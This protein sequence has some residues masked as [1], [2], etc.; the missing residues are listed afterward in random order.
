MGAAQSRV[1]WA[2]ISYS[3]DSLVMELQKS[4]KSTIFS[5]ARRH[6][7]Q[8]S[9]QL[10]TYISMRARWRNPRYNVLRARVL[11]E[12]TE[13]DG[14]L[15]CAVGPAVRDILW[16]NFCRQWVMTSK[17]K[18]QTSNA[19][20]FD[21][22]NS[23]VHSPPQTVR[24]WS[25]RRMLVARPLLLLLTTEAQRAQRNFIFLPDREPRFS[26]GQASDRANREPTRR[27]GLQAKRGEKN[28]ALR[29]GS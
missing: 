21:P 13:L 3:I 19:I 29:A 23:M 25:L 9:L 4:R 15:I 24:T 5:E 20:D 8:S 22:P 7:R 26:A 16:K 1:F 27:V 6:D 2:R 28:T 10:S 17:H 14:G 18:C 12:F 11:S